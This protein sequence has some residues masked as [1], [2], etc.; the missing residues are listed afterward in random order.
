MNI[1]FPGSLMITFADVSAQAE[2]L[3]S[4]TFISGPQIS[5]AIGP[6]NV[7]GITY[8]GTRFGEVTVRRSQK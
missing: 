7:I 2:T 1:R 5:S 6:N 8:A 3:N 4:G